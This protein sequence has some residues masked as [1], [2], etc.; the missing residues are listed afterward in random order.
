VPAVPEARVSIGLRWRDMDMLGHLNQA[1]YHELLE[2]GRSAL[3]ESLGER[4]RFPFVIVRV[5]LDYKREVRRDHETVDVI[6]RVDRV[7]RTSAV[8]SQEI[9]RSDGVVAAEGIT[10]IVAWDMQARTARE[11]TDEERELLTA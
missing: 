3:F 1:V 8:L 2:E 7:G 4:G 6:A 9:V 10:V 11:L 5:E